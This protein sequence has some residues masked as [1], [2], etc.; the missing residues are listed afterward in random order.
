MKKQKQLFNIGDVVWTVD[1]ENTRPVKCPSC[2]DMP[3]VK[4]W[5]RKKEITYICSVC[6]GFG[7]VTYNKYVVRKSFIS[8]IEINDGVWVYRA[9]NG[10]AYFSIDT[11]AECMIFGVR[12][13]SEAAA[14]DL[15]NREIPVAYPYK[16][17]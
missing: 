15:N 7:K 8:K 4:R 6:H 5:H 16:K 2:C 9:D 11:I 13:Y 10:V 14:S 3:T 1:F 17:K 12:E